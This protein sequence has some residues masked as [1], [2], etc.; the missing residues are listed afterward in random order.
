M[1][2]NGIEKEYIK[3]NIDLFRPPTPPLEFLTREKLRGGS[4]VTKKRFRDL[5]LPVPITVIGKPTVEDVKEDLAAWLVHDQPK[6]LIFKDQPNRYYMAEYESMVLDERKF[7]AKGVINFY[8]AEGYRFGLKKTINLTTTSQT[9][10][11]TGQ[12]GTPWKSKTI[13]NESANRFTLEGSNGLKVILNFNFTAGDVLEID[14]R[15]RDVFLNG[16][17]LATAVSLE[18]DWAKGELPVGEVTLQASHDTEL[19][20]DERFY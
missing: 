1:I 15:E 9:Y 5:I 12:I 17:D 3:V 4:R 13:F 18:T 8:L 16:I 14:S 7:R 20:Y 2:F 10:K 11:I 6:K 19:T